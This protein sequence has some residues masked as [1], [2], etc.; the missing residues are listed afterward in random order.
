MPENSKVKLYQGKNTSNSIFFNEA[1]HKND[2]ISYIYI[3][4]LIL[5]KYDANDMM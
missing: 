4:I 2:N 5:K 3:L 1:N